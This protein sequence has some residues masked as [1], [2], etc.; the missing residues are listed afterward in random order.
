MVRPPLQRLATRLHED[1]GPSLKTFFAAD[2]KCAAVFIFLSVTLA[3]QALAVLRPLFP[4]KPSPPYSGEASYLC[5]SDARNSPRIVIPELVRPQ[6]N[7]PPRRA[8]G[9]FRVRTI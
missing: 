3:S 5:G 2:M 7:S 4:A 1:A 6:R 8:S 9:P